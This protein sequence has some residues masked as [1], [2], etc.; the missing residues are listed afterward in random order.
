[1]FQNK[2]Y[3]AA[4][5][6]LFASAF[7][8]AAVAVTA[9]PVTGDQVGLHSVRIPPLQIL[10]LEQKVPNKDCPERVWNQFNTD[11]YARDYML[12]ESGNRLNHYGV[13]TLLFMC[14]FEHAVKNSY[15]PPVRG[16]FLQSIAPPTRG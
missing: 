9:G 5:R 11:E 3:H 6:A 12:N 16:N 13:S 8:T 1:M 10:A 14:H 4:S 2:H 15:K 7:A